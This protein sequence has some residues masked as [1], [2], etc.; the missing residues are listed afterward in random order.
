MNRLGNTWLLAVA[1][2]ALAVVA[3]PRSALAQ[4]SDTGQAAADTSRAATRPAAAPVQTTGVPE[5]LATHPRVLNL[6][7]KQVDRIGKVRVWL[8]GQ[9]STLRGQWQQLTGGRPLR[10]MQPAE[11]RRLAPQL[12]PIMQQLRANSAAALDSVDAILTPQQQQK[13]QAN[14]AEYRERAQARGARQG[15]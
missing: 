13:L 9:D 6:T 4:A 1:G 15:Q 2:L 10:G 11:R 8:H 5:Y 7:P 3:T 14:L 12:Q